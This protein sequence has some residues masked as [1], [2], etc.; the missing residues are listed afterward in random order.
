MVYLHPM[1]EG[2]MDGSAQFAS[3][4]ILLH[5]EYVSSIKALAVGAF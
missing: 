4:Q 1:W 2:F 5:E 3:N